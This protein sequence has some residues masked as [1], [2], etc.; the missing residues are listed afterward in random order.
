MVLSSDQT[1][2]AAGTTISLSLWAG[3]WF[4]KFWLLYLE[5]S[6]VFWECHG[7]VGQCRPLE[8]LKPQFCRKIYLINEVEKHTFRDRYHIL[9]DIKPCGQK[10]YL[11]FLLLF[12]FRH[13]SNI[14]IS[15]LLQ[16]ISSNTLKGLVHFQNKNVLIICSAQ[17]HPRCSCLSFFS[18]KVIHEFACPFSPAR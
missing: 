11:P 2:K 12:Y 4:E 6:F 18:R 9:T 7:H 16:Q 10:I 5:N 17:W 8:I 1:D 15:C 3:L 13:K 14:S